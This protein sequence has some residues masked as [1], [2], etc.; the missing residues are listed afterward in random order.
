MRRT[1]VRRV[2]PSDAMVVRQGD[3]AR[4]LHLVVRG[5]VAVMV[6]C[7]HGHQRTFMIAG[8]GD[9][10]GELALLGG[11]EAHDCAVRTL[12]ETETLAVS[13]SDFEACLRRNSQL[14]ELVART[15][16]ER[17]VRLAVQ[18]QETA[19]M[20]VEQRVRRRL[21]ELV[22]VYERDVAGTVIPLTQE[23][24][25]GLAGT[26]RGTV[27]RVLRQEEA[28]GSLLIGRHRLTVIDAQALSRRAAAG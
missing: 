22:E 2:F 16:A 25:A 26:A 21:V 24:V 18:L 19:C 9:S 15:L 20:P 27:N 10:F 13:R 11:G 17:V 12:E 28:L 5:R 3:A 23:D 1:A 6:T 4:S 14:G 8:P 7:G